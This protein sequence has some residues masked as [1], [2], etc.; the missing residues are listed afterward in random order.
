[1]SNA[2]LQFPAKGRCVFQ[3][4]TITG[5]GQSHV[6][7]R[8]DILTRL[9]R[10]CGLPAWS[11]IAF[12]LRNAELFQGLGLGSQILA[13]GHLLSPLS[14]AEENPKSRAYQILLIG[15]GNRCMVGYGWPWL[16]DRWGKTPSRLPSS[17]HCGS[18]TLPFS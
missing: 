4:M 16:L 18:S 15:S 11:Q 17:N 9:R 3:D 12:V 7:L 10:C 8:I 13:W 1:M 2:G 6:L 5:F 14:R